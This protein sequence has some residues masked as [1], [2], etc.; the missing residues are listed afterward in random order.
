MYQ[1]FTG[2]YRHVEGESL[3]G[4]N[5][6]LI[7]YGSEN[8]VDYWIGVNSWPDWGEDGTFRILRGSNEVDIEL[9]ATAGLPVIPN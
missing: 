4:H 3:G 8:G 6:R 9:Q 5:L 1:M 7:G 2:I